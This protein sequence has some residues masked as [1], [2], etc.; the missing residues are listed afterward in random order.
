M[1]N[2]EKMIVLA[3]GRITCLRC[4]ARAK[5][6]KLQCRKAALRDSRTQKCRLHGGRSKGPVTEEGKRKSA[7]APLKTGRFTREAIVRDSVS[8]VQLRQLRDAMVILEMARGIKKLRGRK[9]LGYTPLE[10]LEDVWVMKVR[11]ALH[12]MEQ[13]RSG[14][15]KIVL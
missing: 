4:T 3:G 7:L 5:H 6:S 8:R 14:D 1:E 9:P 13:S 10:S 11:D 2:L 15:E 12:R